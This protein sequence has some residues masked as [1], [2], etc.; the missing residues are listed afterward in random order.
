LHGDTRTNEAGEMREL[1]VNQI[2]DLDAVP[3]APD[4]QVLTG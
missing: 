2:L 3:I 1:S 4:E